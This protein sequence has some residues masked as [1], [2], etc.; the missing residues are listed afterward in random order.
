MISLFS[1]K[2]DH[3]FLTR[4][5]KSR[6]GKKEWLWLISFI[7]LIIRTSILWFTLCW[8]SRMNRLIIQYEWADHPGWIGWSSR[9]NRLTIL[10]WMRLYAL[11]IYLFDV[12]QNPWLGLTCFNKI[13]GSCSVNRSLLLAT[14]ES[15]LRITAV[16]IPGALLILLL[17]QCGF[18]KYHMFLQ[19]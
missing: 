14:C 16:G 1:L 19:L 7:R 8:S 15:K 17:S 3:H 12:M 6:S 13:G 18:H 5:P 11:Y 9:M 10:V 4:P 2:V